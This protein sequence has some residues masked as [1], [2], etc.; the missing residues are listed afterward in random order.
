MD[1]V[2][3]K[4]IIIGGN[5]VLWMKYM[6]HYHNKENI[7]FVFVMYNPCLFLAF[8][9]LRHQKQVVTLASVGEEI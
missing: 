3:R 1:E 6:L 4:H 9:R 7:K 8:S 5:T 2:K